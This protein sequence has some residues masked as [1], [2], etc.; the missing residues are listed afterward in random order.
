MA[1]E[2]IPRLRGAVH[3]HED[4]ID[5]AIPG[6]H[7]GRR[8]H[9]PCHRVRMIRDKRTGSLGRTCDRSRERKED[10]NEAEGEH[11]GKESIRADRVRA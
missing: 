1:S 4:G 8:C 9:L 5:A 11:C 3:K 7:G 10:R 2:G 6:L